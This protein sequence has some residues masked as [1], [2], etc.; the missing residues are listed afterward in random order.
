M[1]SCCRTATDPTRG[2]VLLPTTA[3]A[4]P[5]LPQRLRASGATAHLT[6]PLDVRRVLEVLDDLRSPGAADP[7]RWS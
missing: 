1:T 3:D 2:Y 6:K 7:I 4:T 5:G